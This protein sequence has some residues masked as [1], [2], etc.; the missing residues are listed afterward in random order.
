MMYIVLRELFAPPIDCDSRRSSTPEPLA[1][2][3]LVERFRSPPWNGEG[4]GLSRL[5]GE[6]LPNERGV[7]DELSL[8]RWP[9]HRSR[10]TD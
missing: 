2:P 1:P 6:K 4:C 7:G 10:S 5:G 8:A 9:P 3:S